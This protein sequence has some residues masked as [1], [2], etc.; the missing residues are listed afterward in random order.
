MISSRHPIT[1]ASVALPWRINSSAL[2]NHTSVP[3]DNPEICNNSAKVVGCVSFNMP[4]TKRVPNSGIPNVPVSEPI[5]SAVTPSTSGDSKIRI[6]SGSSVGIVFGSIPDKSCNIR[7]TV[8]SSCPR[9]SSFKI[10][11]WIEWKSKWVVRHSA[12]K[13][14]AGYWIGVKSYTSI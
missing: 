4:R 7:I 6:T 11:S 14:S 13:S 9:I 5:C 10:L 8:G 3:W 1:S 12:F 2:P